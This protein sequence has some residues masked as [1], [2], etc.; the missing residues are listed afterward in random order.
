MFFFQMQ[1][2]DGEPTDVAFGVYLSLR[3]LL[4]PSAPRQPRLEV[5]DQF[6]VPGRRCMVMEDWT[7]LGCAAVVVGEKWNLLSSPS[8]ASLAS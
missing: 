2:S 8:E 5:G 1:K 4:P 6:F 3:G 7:R